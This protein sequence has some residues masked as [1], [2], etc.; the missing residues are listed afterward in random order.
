MT[1]LAAWQNFYV[2]VGS[3]AGALIGLQFVVM[4]LVANFPRI[5]GLAEAGQV[6]STPTIVHFATVLFLAAALTAPWPSPVCVAILLAFAGP[7]GVVYAI[8]VTLRLRRHVL[9]Y[10]PEFE[11]W[12]FYAVLPLIAYA[13]LGVAAT[14]LIH[15]RPLASQFS[16]AA[17][18]LL[19]LLIGI[20]NAWD[21]VTYH[22]FIKPRDTNPSDPNG[23]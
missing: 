17:S 20:H 22:V 16:V 10:H 21:N 12:L 13:S 3:S 7:A 4:A 6:Y 2:I 19:L 23:Q 9:V 15:A 8:V 11:D 5:P 1:P 14:L 18:L